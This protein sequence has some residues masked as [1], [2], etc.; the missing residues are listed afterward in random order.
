MVYASALYFADELDRELEKFYVRHELDLKAMP[1]DRLRHFFRIKSYEDFQRLSQCLQIPDTIS[2]D[3]RCQV[4]GEFALAVVL[5]R[6]AYPNRWRDCADLL[7]REATQLSRIFN[8]TINFLYDKHGHLL[9][10]LGQPWLGADNIAAYAAAVHR[11]SGGRYDNCWA[12]VDGTARAICRPGRLQREYYS[13]HYRGHV[14]KFQSLVA[15]DGLIVN[16]YGPCEG[17]RHDMYM[18]GASKLRHRLR[19]RNL[20][21]GKDYC[22][23]GDKGYSISAEVQSPYKGGNI[24]EAEIAFNLVMSKCRL[25]VELGFQR[26]CTQFAFGNYRENQKL[27]WQQSAKAYLVSAVLANCL[28]CMYGFELVF[29]KFGLQPPSLETYLRF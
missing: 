17:R 20:I 9:R 11:A 19:L 7:G 3:N 18:L 13:G 26:I 12:F 15:P 5:R 29:Q 1:R 27:F 2:C 21:W 24:S 22:I 23:F 8:A 25:I 4:S 10:S 16:M 6:L 28:T 14:I